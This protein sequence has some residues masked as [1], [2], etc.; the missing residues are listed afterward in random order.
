MSI[1][2]DILK[3]NVASR[4]WYSSRNAGNLAKE[5]MTVTRGKREIKHGKKKAESSKQSPFSLAWK[6]V[7]GERLCS[8]LAPKEGQKRA[9]AWIYLVRNHQSP[10]L[11]VLAESRRDTEEGEAGGE[12]AQ[13]VFP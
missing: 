13:D 3:P 7:V 1:E 2:D 9:L 5:G 8:A 4:L 6:V 10:C 12:R 11:S